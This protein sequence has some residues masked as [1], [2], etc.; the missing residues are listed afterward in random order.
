MYRINVF[1]HVSATFD[2]AN[3]SPEH[4][5]SE[6]GHILIA[7]VLTALTAYGVGC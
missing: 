6:D 1:G 4:G 3:D 2:D 5:G 7:E